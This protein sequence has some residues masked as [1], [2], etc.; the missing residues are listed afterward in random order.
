MQTRERRTRF[1]GFGRRPPKPSG[2][3]SNRPGAHVPTPMHIRSY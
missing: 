2:R 3:F 1:Y